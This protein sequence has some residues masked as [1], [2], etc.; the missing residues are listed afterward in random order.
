[1]G[2]QIIKTLFFCNGHFNEMWHFNDALSD[3]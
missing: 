3:Q 2:S 1:M